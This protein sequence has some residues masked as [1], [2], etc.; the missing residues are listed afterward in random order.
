MR[1][2]T[3]SPALAAPLVQGGGQVV[4]LSAPAALQAA[5]PRGARGVAPIA[6]P[7]A[8]RPRRADHIVRVAL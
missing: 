7:P 1:Q 5:T 2:Q 4:V 3:S 8:A 6:P